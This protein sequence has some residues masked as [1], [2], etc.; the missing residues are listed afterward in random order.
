MQEL[1]KK[2]LIRKEI[3]A[4]KK[5]I[6]EDLTI[7]LSRKI[8]ARIAQTE[9]FQNAGCIALYY[10]LNDEVQTSELIEEWYEKKNIVLPVTSGENINFHTYKGK[11]SLHIGAL[12]ISEPAVSEV[13]QPDEIDLFIV[14]GV[15]FDRER[16]RLGRGKGYYDRYLAG[17]AKQTIGVCF[18]FQLI[19]TI[20]SEKHDIKMDMIITEKETVD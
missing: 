11:E 13:T 6:S 17:Y 10:A 9:L 3:A 7:K 19:E 14:P 18:D 12:G 4:R 1:D 20:P 5:N 8:C 15:A 16:N 2:R